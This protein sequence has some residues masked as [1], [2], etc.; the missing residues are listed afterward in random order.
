MIT[1]LYRLVI[2]E[3]DATNCFSIN[4]QVFANNNQHN[5]VK[6]HFNVVKHAKGSTSRWNM[7]MSR[8]IFRS[9]SPCQKQKCIGIYKSLSLFIFTLNVNWQLLNDPDGRIDS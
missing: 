7:L 8:I 3:P 2:T 6:I 5:I 9:S 4:F 1:S